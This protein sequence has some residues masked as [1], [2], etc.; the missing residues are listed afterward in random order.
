MN[1]GILNVPNSS[2]MEHASRQKQTPRGRLPLAHL[3][4]QPTL[5]LLCTLA[6]LRFHCAQRQLQ[7]SS[8]CAHSSPSSCARSWR[9]GWPSFSFS[10]NSSSAD[11]LPASWLSTDAALSAAAA[12]AAAR[13]HHCPCSGHLLLTR[14]LLLLL[15]LDG[16]V[17][18][19]CLLLLLP[20]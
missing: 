14:P 6:L 10:S 5:C 15:L 8:C 9:V 18:R 1:S 19:A 20:P 4:K 13:S 11:L 16:A 2:S 7:H 3:S 12:A 17:H